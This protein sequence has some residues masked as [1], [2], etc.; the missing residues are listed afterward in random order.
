MEQDVKPFKTVEEQIK[1]LSERGLIIDD[2]KEARQFLLNLNYYR[3]SAYSLTLRNND[4]FYNGVHFSDIMQIYNFDMELR[5][6][7]L[8]LMEYIEVSIRTHI[9][10]FHSKTYGP[11]GYL[12]QNAFKNGA[13]YETFK[14]DYENAIKEYGSKEAFVK[15][16]KECYSGK[17]PIWVLV[18]LLSFGSLSRLFKNL[19]VGLQDEICKNNY[20]VIGKIYIENWLQGFTI[21]RNIC[22][23][24]GRIYNREIPFSLKLH[25]RDKRMLTQNHLRLDKATKQLFVYLLVA[26][27]ITTDA[28]I[29]QTFIQR[30]KSLI[31]K[32][33]FVRLSNYGFPQNW[34]ELLN[35]KE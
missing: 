28:N 34:K 8:Y 1:I 31:A 19:D 12:N 33:P 4:R 9:G 3:I 15:H 10:Y 5:A 13:Y 24:R 17:F 6:S 20:G 7:L 30:F 23:H 14:V 2:Q 25:T 29:W 22:A 11:L 35:I 16:H 32:Y 27:K 26:Q 18:E 21:L